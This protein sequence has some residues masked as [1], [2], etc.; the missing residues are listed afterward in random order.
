MHRPCHIIDFDRDCGD[1]F[2]VHISLLAPSHIQQES[3]SPA[4]AFHGASLQPAQRASRIG[5]KKGQRGAAIGGGEPKRW[6]QGLYIRP[7]FAPNMKTLSS[8]PTLFFF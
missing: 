1:F 8:P 5:R 3:D 7:I 6:V 2:Y 4:L